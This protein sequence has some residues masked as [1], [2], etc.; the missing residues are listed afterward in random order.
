MSNLHDLAEQLKVIALE[1]ELSI[2]QIE[3][4]TLQ[5]VE[6]LLGESLNISGSVFRKVKRLVKEALQTRDDNA[7]RDNIKTQVKTWLDNNF[8]NYE[9]DLKRNDN[10]LCIE[11]WPFGKP[12]VEE[13]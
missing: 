12:P 13:Y 3:N 11:L 1:R 4:A 5:N 10:K 7:V 6:N 9:F 2:N 8:P